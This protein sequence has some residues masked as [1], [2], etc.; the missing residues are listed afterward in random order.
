MNPFTNLTRFFTSLTTD[1]TNTALVVAVIAFIFCGIMIFRGTEENV[2]RFQ[3]AT[4]WVGAGV[5]VI[6]L[7]K[8]IV[9][10]L[11]AGVA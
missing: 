4:M 11:K 1:L 10:W 6:V 9:G 2:P 3:K 5:I 7:A 8:I